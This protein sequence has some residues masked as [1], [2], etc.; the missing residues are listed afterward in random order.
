[1]STAVETGS[2]PAKSNNNNNNS[3]S[4]SNSSGNNNNGNPSPNAKGVQRR[5]L[6]SNPTLAPLLPT[7]PIIHYPLPHL[8]TINNR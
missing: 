8:C 5:Q 1:M 3:G 6:V 4:N 2:S 7:L